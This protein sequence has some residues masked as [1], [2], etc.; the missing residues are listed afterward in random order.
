MEPV[1]LGRQNENRRQS[2][3]IEKRGG[4]AAGDEPVELLAPEWFATF[5]VFWKGNSA[6]GRRHI[7][8][9][10]EEAAA[11]DTPERCI[12]M[13]QHALR[14]L[15]LVEVQIV[16]LILTRYLEHVQSNA[17]SPA[18]QI[19]REVEATLSAIRRERLARR[20]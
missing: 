14:E 17:D 10:L 18:R 20:K 12:C 11:E 16:K 2:N 13:L 15:G 9:L 8:R 19:V 6:R 4:S 5:C 3:R 7:L 1:S